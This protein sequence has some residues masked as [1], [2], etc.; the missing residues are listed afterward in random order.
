MNLSYSSVAA[1]A[2]NT[3][4]LFHHNHDE[5]LPTVSRYTRPLFSYSLLI[6]ANC[7]L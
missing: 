5:K 2:A 6:Y 4:G 3:D 1:L 7:Y